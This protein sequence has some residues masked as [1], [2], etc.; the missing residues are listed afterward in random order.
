MDPPPTEFV[1]F[2]FQPK[3]KEIVSLATAEDDACADLIDDLVEQHDRVSESTW[4]I[5]GRPPLAVSSCTHFFCPIST[6]CVRFPVVLGDGNTY[7][8]VS[9]D[10]YFETKHGYITSPVTNQQM[11]H[12]KSYFLNRNLRCARDHWVKTHLPGLAQRARAAHEKQDGRPLSCIGLLKVMRL[13]VLHG[14]D[15]CVIGAEHGPLPDPELV[16][17]LEDADV[18]NW[19][20]DVS[21]HVFTAHCVDTSE[22]RSSFR[23]W[24]SDLVIDCHTSVPVHRIIIDNDRRYRARVFDVPEGLQVRTENV[25][26]NIEFV[27]MYATG[28]DRVTAEYW[29]QRNEGD[30]VNA[31][32]DM[33]GYGRPSPRQV[34][35]LASVNASE[36]GFSEGTRRTVGLLSRIQPVAVRGYTYPPIGPLLTNMGPSPSTSSEEPVLDRLGPDRSFRIFDERLSRLRPS[37]PAPLVYRSPPVHYYDEAPQMDFTDA[38]GVDY[39]R[40]NVHGPGRAIYLDEVRNELP[41][42]ETRADRRRTNRQRRDEERGR[43][44]G[45]R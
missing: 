16:G 25:E 1:R 23:R 18:L 20:R 9:L 10:Q 32:I 22:S 45:R 19:Q 3:R 39:M 35:S 40:A 21:E 14:E 31:I 37:S 17:T 30:A 29:L 34:A 24:V 12:G 5:D 28:C 2:L 26:R 42:E 7:E 8:Q 44:M 15:C 36:R 13:M 6:T 43:R 11:A 33:Q 41:R 27:M 4:G 38:Q